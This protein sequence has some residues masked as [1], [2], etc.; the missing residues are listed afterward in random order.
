MNS[1]KTELK[2]YQKLNTLPLH[3]EVWRPESSVPL[4][5]HDCVELLLTIDGNALCQINENTRLKF[6][7]GDLFVI[8]GDLAHRIYDL[9]D[10][11]AYRILFDISLLDGLCTEVKNSPGYNSMISMSSLSFSGYGYS[12]A[13]Y[14]NEFYFDRIV[15]MFKEVICEYEHGEYM[16]ENYMIQ[17]LHVL[18]TLIMKCYDDRVRNKKITPADLAVGIMQTRLHE[19]LVIADIAKEFGITPRYFRTL[20]EE[21]WGVP[22]AQFLTDLRLRK[23]KT[24]LLLADMSITDIAMACGFCDNSHF[25]NVFTKNEGISPREYRKTLQH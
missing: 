2:N 15:A 24:L 17:C 11:S 16:H 4:H 1:N 7:K 23:A 5:Y 9:K 18:I 22:P 21:R 6:H 19:K 12:A 14:V 3:V 10:F 8:S 25:S 13:L 20:F